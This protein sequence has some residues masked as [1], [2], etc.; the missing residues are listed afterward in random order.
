MRAFGPA[1]GAGET[2]PGREVDGCTADPPGWKC[3]MGALS[4]PALRPLCEDL[5]TRRQAPRRVASEAEGR[6]G[7]RAGPEQIGELGV[8]AAPGQQR[9]RAVPRRTRVHA[10]KH[11]RECRHQS[12]VVRSTTVAA[13]LLHRLYLP[14]VDHRADSHVVGS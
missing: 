12:V 6:A 14:R 9:L 7:A 8:D 10:C 1:Y 11:R 2:A 5:A 4:G 3:T 13:V